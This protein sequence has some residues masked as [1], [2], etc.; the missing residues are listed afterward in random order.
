VNKG[1]EVKVAVGKTGVLVL[2]GVFVAGD[3]VFVRVG[4]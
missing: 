4:V 2:V 3:G 1:V